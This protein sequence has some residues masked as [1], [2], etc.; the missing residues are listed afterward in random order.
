MT[1][2]KALKAQPLALAS[3]R[4]TLAISARKFKP[5]TEGPEGLKDKTRATALHQVYN[6]VWSTVFGLSPKVKAWSSGQTSRDPNA[7]SLICQE[8]GHVFKAAGGKRS[9]ACG[10]CDARRTRAG[11]ITYPKDHQPWV[12]S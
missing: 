8:A 7:S 10:D 4:M 6:G 2:T 3:A 1:K 5:T 11:K 9:A 12:P